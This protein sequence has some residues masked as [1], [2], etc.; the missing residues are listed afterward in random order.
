M[1]FRFEVTLFN[2]GSH[3][4]AGKTTTRRVSGSERARPATPPCARPS[5]LLWGQDIIT[6]ES[7]KWNDCAERQRLDCLLAE[8]ET[9]SP[10]LKLCSTQS[11]PQQYETQVTA[12]WHDRKINRLNTL[13]KN[14]KRLYKNVINPLKGWNVSDSWK[15]PQQTKFRSWRN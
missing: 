14:Y 1:F 13:I 11:L 8:T 12:K 15:Q 10:E 2:L 7:V 3:V 6:A 9:S 5:P 4:W